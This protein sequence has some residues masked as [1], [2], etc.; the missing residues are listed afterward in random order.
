MNFVAEFAQENLEK[1]DE[2]TSA[3]S[4]RDIAIG[5][6]VLALI[7]PTAWVI[8]W[9]VRRSIRRLPIPDLPVGR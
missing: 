3:V 2:L 4:G 5:C 1:V 6:A 8:G 7:W 9:I